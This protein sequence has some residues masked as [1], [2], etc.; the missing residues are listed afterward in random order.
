VPA[1][2]VIAEAGGKTT[3]DEA[4]RLRRL[5]QPRGVTDLLLVTSVD[6]MTRAREE[7][8]RQGFTVA[9]APVTGIRTSV[10]R[11]EDRLGQARRWGQELGARVYYRLGAAF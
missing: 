2:A 9:P 10:E 11:P 7:F 4:V 6:H 5:L 3:R 8:E 1:E